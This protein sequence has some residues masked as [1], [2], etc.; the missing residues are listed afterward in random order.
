M[1]EKKSESNFNVNYANK[2]EEFPWMSYLSLNNNN[3]PSD[4]I[5]LGPRASVF[6][7][8]LAIS[9][10]FKTKQKCACSIPYMNVC[11]CIYC[12]KQCG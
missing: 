11:V 1:M 8:P 9:G 6:F 3:N 2:R 12:I 10:I 5:F 7:F 4:H